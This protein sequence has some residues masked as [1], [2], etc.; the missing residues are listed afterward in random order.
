MAGKDLE[1]G[2]R[3]YKGQIVGSDSFSLT[4]NVKWLIQVF[5]FVLGIAY[6]LYQ[7]QMKIQMMAKD[8][9][10]HKAHIE[11]LMAIHQQIED[12]RIATLETEVEWYKKELNVNPLAIF[13]KD[14][15]KKRGN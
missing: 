13:K 1:N 3:S 5:A 9:E 12:E 7:Y 4:I 10:E 11:E 6:T 8:L 14:K 15:R 2:A